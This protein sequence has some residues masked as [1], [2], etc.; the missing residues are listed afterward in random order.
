MSNSARDERTGIK[1]LRPALARLVE[2]E[3]I[4]TRRVATWTKPPGAYWRP[5]EV[6]AWALARVELS[7][8]RD[9]RQLPLPF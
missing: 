2:E 3:R 5:M 8:E 1:G 6:L 4:A 7:A 9:G